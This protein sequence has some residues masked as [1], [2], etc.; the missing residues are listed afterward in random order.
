MDVAHEAARAF[1][2]ALLTAPKFLEM[3]GISGRAAGQSSNTTTKSPLH[4][5]HLPFSKISNSSH[6]KNLHNPQ[7]N[8][9]QSTSSPS[10][11]LQQ[12]PPTVNSNVIPVL[13]SGSY[14]YLCIRI[15]NGHKFV[16]LCG[17]DL[18]TDVAFFSSVR[19][20]YFTA[21]GHFSR[22]FSFASWWR[23]DHCEFHQVNL[24][25]A[26]RFV[27]ALLTLLVPQICHRQ[28]SLG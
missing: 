26:S 23:Y 21:R 18:K 15:S 11:Q 9:Q 3:E 25:L 10:I 8:R 17:E 6:Q 27:F 24:T 5:Q 12:M 19:R 16:E 4:G 14:V 20:Q 2:A 28:Q 1:Q 22:Y 13:I 7:S